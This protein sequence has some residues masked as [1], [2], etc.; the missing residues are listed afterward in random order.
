MSDAL[1]TDNIGLVH[2]YARPFLHRHDYADIIGAGIIGLAKAARSYNSDL[3]AFST[4]AMFRIRAE[5]LI[6]IN[7][8]SPIVRG[9]RDQLACDQPEAISLNAC[10][11]SD[12]QETWIE[13]LADPSDPF[14]G[15]CRD[16]QGAIR[17]I[18]ETGLDITPSQRQAL[19]KLLDGQKL[20][21]VEQTNL[22]HF[23]RINSCSARK[24]REILHDNITA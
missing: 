4:H 24:I 10:T 22:F 15:T 8:L 11:S 19:I 17:R 13:H 2:K 16:A 23:R 5:I 1:V 9:G 7:R 18:V 21:H 20:N 6:Y 14:A 3:A 12:S